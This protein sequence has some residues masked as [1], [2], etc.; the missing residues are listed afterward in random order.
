MTDETAI[1]IIACGKMF[2]AA[3]LLGVVCAGISLI[4]P[5]YSLDWRNAASFFFNAAVWSACSGVVL[6]M[7]G[8][9]RYVMS[10]KK[11]NK[12]KR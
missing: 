8:D 11:K 1:E 10:L 5:T 2:G 4:V 9:I 6:F 12:R 7:V 3:F